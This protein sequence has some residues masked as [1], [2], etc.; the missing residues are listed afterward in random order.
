MAVSKRLRF[1]VF[2]RDNHTCRY[3]GR[4]APEVRLT[5]DHV[6]PE[7]LGGK[8]EPSNLVTACADCNAGKSSIAPDAGIVDDVQ[9]DAIRWARAMRR[10]AE[11]HR[12]KMEIRRDFGDA[13]IEH[14][15]GWRVGEEPVPIDGNWRSS[16]ENFYD[17]GMYLPDVLDA[18]RLAM[19]NTAV[20]PERKFR[21]FCGICWRMVGEIQDR[22]RAIVEAEEVDGP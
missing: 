15:E 18:V 7:A 1:E 4:A 8:D 12:Q 20:L 2:R 21:Y 3:C 16:V 10:A 22:A 13:F 17:H 14:W 6:L 9:Q 5:I 19:E 11:I